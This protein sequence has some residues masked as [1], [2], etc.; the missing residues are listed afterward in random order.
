M[1]SLI[2]QAK[3]PRRDELPDALPPLANFPA[4]ARANL[5]AD[6]NLTLQ[7]LEAVEIGD[8]SE[9]L[10]IDKSSWLDCELL[11]DSMETGIGVSGIERG[12]LVSQG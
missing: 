8:R 5:Q 3:P 7:L 12:N 11:K 1:G 10:A 4:R 6:G 9:D 2:C